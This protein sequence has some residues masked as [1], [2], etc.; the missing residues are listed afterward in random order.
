MKPPR[1][2]TL[3][4]DQVLWFLRTEKMKVQCHQFI[5]HCWISRSNRS[6]SHPL[7]FLT[8]NKHRFKVA[9]E[10][11]FSIHTTEDVKNLSN[12]NSGKAEEARGSSTLSGYLPLL[13]SNCEII[14]R[15]AKTR[16]RAR[17]HNLSEAANVKNINIPSIIWSK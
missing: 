4:W 2:F 11:H 16:T 1:T 13:T 14:C 15:K 8:S 5:S 3:T 10:R 12:S 17:K 6:I 9:P 7:G